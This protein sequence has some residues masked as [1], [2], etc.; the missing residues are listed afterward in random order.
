[1]AKT[2]QTFDAW[3]IERLKAHGVYSAATDGGHGRGVIAALERFQAKSGL[4]VTGKADAATV[5]ALRSGPDDPVM[6]PAEPVWLREARRFMDLKEI[7]GAKSNPTILGWAKALGGW[8]A[9]YYTNDDIPWCG[10]FL[11]HIMG[12]T[13]PK[14]LLPSNPLSAKAWGTFGKRLSSPALGAVMVFNRDGGDH[15]GLYLG[16]TATAY[17]ILG[18]NQSNSVSLTWIAKKRLVDGGIRWP[19]TVAAPVVGGRIHLA[20]NGSPLSTNEA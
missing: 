18:G 17:R 16:E 6:P 13:L 9:S 1:M 10:L 20:A 11:A 7:S 15:V 12:A 4:P 5:P 3:L 2:P 19:S 14:E 8:I